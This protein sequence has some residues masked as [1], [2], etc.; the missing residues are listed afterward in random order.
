MGGHSATRKP[1]PCL[2]LPE[3]PLRQAN[4]PGYN[5]LQGACCSRKVPCTVG[6]MCS[7]LRRAPFTGVRP[8]RQTSCNPHPLQVR[9]M[10]RGVSD[11][12]GGAGGEVHSL[13]A[14]SVIRAS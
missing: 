2:L 6:N 14:T 12:L 9:S 4:V 5:G 10:T 3:P 13:D 7:A 1:I 8:S 11:P